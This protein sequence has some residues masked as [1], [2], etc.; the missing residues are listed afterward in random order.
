MK[1]ILGI[2]LAAA[3]MLT[4]SSC[5]GPAASSN[6]AASEGAAAPTGEATEITFATWG[7][8]EE[9]QALVDLY[10][11]TQSEIHVTL[12]V[13][14]LTE[15]GTLMNA[16]LGTDEGPD[17]L[18]AGLQT[19]LWGNAGMLAELQ[20][21]VAQDN[22]DLSVFMEYPMKQNYVGDILY[23]IPM[24]TDSYAIAYN[25]AIFDKYGVEYPQEGWNWNDYEALAEELNGKIQAAG[26]SEIASALAINEPAHGTLLLLTNNG[27]QLYNDDVTACALNCP[28]S[29]EMLEMVQR[30]IESGA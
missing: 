29:V 16:T 20:D 6:G 22:I 4:V 11:E 14:P 3:I 15:F 27:A 8:E 1:R 2:V 12:Q 28:E 26:G 18:W 30:M 21:L 23:G 19:R 7:S 17:V 13:T 10:N 25:T 24:Y 9:M 5:G